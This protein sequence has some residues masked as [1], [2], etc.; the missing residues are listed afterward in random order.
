MIRLLIKKKEESDISSDISDASVISMRIEQAI[1]TIGEHLNVSGDSCVV[2]CSTA[3]P[4]S[5][6]LPTTTTYYLLLLP[7][8]YLL[9]CCQHSMVHH[10]NGNIFGTC[11]QRQLIPKS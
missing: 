6:K 5:V 3:P 8:T 9:L 10:C 2:N 1:T 4:K 7:T 11:F